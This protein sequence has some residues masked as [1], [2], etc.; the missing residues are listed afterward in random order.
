MK[1]I[2]QPSRKTELTALEVAVME[3][4]CVHFM[5]NPSIARARCRSTS[6]I[7]TQVYRIRKFLGVRNNY[8]MVAVYWQKRSAGDREFLSWGVS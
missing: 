2:P 1:N 8:E 7:N 6:T 5:D 4:I 3:G